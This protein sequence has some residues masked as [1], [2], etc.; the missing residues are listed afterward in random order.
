[1]SSTLTSA[2]ATIP[3]L[4]SFLYGGG[5]HLAGGGGLVV[6]P[7]AALAALL[8]SASLSFGFIYVFRIHFMVVDDPLLAMISAGAYGAG[9]SQFLLFPNILVGWFVSCLYSLAPVAPWYSLVVV[10]LECLSFWIAYLLLIR[11]GSPGWAL[12]VL[13]LLEALSSCLVTYTVVA[14]VSSAVGACCAVNRPARRG[15]VW[16]IASAVLMI[17]GFLLRPPSMVVGLLVAAPVVVGSAMRGGSIR[18]AALFAAVLVSCALASALNTW[19]YSQSP[20]DMDSLTRQDDAHRLVDYAPVDYSSHSSELGSM[21]WSEN[22]LRSYYDWIFAD[23]DVY[24]VEN[25]EKLGKMLPFSERYQV[26]PL[27]VIRGVVNRKAA[28]AIVS[29]FSL[30]VL[31]RPARHGAGRGLPFAIALCFLLGLVA[32][33]VRQRLVDNAL[34]ALFVSAPICICLVRDWDTTPCI[35]SIPSGDSPRP[36]PATSCRRWGGAILALLFLFSAIAF[37][38]LTMKAPG[39]GIPALDR[40]VDRWMEEN[41]DEFVVT[42]AGFQFMRDRPAFELSVPERFLQTVKVG[43]WSIDGTRW[44]SQLESWGVDPRHLLLE[45]AA[46]DNLVF[47]PDDAEQLRLV[48]TFI[49][50][51]SGRNVAVDEVADFGGGRELYRLRYVS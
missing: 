43:S 12:A 31:C 45:L 24:S 37:T 47:L 40:A 38:A 50:E 20:R 33:V 25:L 46:K 8:V 27:G 51:H 15:G 19:A 4:R 5:W 36:L 6:R 1:M 32:L 35:R 29:I 18:V 7:R 11:A 23:F 10:G 2:P 26:S 9:T 41:P 14:A 49:S 28:L 44:Y 21:G 34:A 42:G 30:A 17:A 48:E 16:P 3:A 39:G 13:V 22:D